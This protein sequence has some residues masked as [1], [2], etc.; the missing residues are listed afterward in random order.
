MIPPNPTD[1]EPVPVPA[2]VLA[3]FTCLALSAAG[4][5]PD[6][7]RVV[8]GLMIEADLVGADAH[9]IFRLPQYVRRLQAGGA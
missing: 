7:A 4:L 9:G 1:Q 6:D 5:P 2:E 3:N 8:A